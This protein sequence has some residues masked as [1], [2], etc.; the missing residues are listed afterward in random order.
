MHRCFVRFFTSTSQFY[1]ASVSSGSDQVSTFV[2]YV[3]SCVAGMWIEIDR[4][5]TGAKNCSAN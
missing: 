5:I 1:H 3:F 4:V 2:S